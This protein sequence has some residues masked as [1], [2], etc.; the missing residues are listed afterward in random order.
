[1]EN[2]QMTRHKV[3]VVDDEAVVRDSLSEWLSRAGF[4][5]TVAKDGN[6]ALEQF[7]RSRVDAMVLDWKMP[8]RD[9]MS[10]LR[11]VKSREPKTRIIVITA[12]GT[13]ENA[14]EAMKNGASDYLL[15][16][17]EPADLEKAIRGA[18]EAAVVEKPPIREVSSVSAPVE[19][20]RVVS[21]APAAGTAVVKDS[22]AGVDKAP[23]QKQ[24]IWAKAGVVSFRLC[25][26]NFKC[27][28]CEFAQALAEGKVSDTAA[29]GMAGIIEKLAEKPGPERQCRYM[30]SGD[31]NFKL[32]PN[33]YQCFKC[34]YD[35]QIQ[36]MMER[37]MAGMMH[38][39]KARV[40]H[41]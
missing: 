21:E 5:V 3:M 29:G 39:I 40:S 31:V 24:C 32:C 36:E 13:V 28:T 38:K 41:K 8:G 34:A 17:F 4:D 15:K 9:G 30:L 35:Q 33:V 2:T 10:V 12:Y 37:K 23:A 19:T 20:D 7:Q 14:V 11:E 25:P 1:M 16:P 27:E 26:S 22:K 18:L 6:E